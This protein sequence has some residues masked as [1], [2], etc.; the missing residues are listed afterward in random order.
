MVEA[1]N[2]RFRGMISS[3]TGLYILHLIKTLPI[4]QVQVTTTTANKCN[5]VETVTMSN[6]KIV[7]SGKIDT[8]NIILIS[9]MNEE[10]TEGTTKILNL[11]D[12]YI[13]H[14]ISCT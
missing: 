3:D 12:Y 10:L 7:D 1:G 13:L 14:F 4:K 5:N 8:P 2:S 9:K 11:N 6:R